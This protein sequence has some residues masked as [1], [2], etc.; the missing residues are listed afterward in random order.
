MDRVYILNQNSTS[1]PVGIGA[2]ISAGDIHINGATESAAR[3]EKKNGRAS[4]E[5]P[6]QAFPGLAGFR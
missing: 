3:R 6:N 2:W 5:E 1:Q 4:K